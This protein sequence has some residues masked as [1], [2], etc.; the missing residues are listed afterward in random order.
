VNRA[1]SLVILRFSFFVFR[2]SFSEVTVVRF[3]HRLF[4]PRLL[5]RVFLDLHLILQVQLDIHS[6]ILS[7]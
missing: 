3:F 6:L 4:L 5:V 7:V 2:F 1:I